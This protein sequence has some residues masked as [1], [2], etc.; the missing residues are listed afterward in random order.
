MT[1]FV[2]LM[3]MLVLLAPV[4]VADEPVCL[5]FC[6]PGYPGNT[7]EAQ[8]TMDHFASG[9]NSATGWKPGTLTAVYHESGSAGVERLSS[10]DAAVAIV[11]LPFYLK[12]R[13]ELALEPL[14]AAV[15]T[16]GGEGTWS[17][18]AAKGKLS[19]P[20]DLAG[21]TVTGLPAYLPALVRGP[22]LS[23]WGELP[24]NMT[25]QFTSRA[26]SALRKASR[27]E[28][29]AVLLDV[30]QIE[31]LSS[32]PFGESLEVVHTSG[33]L[34]GSVL[35]SVGGRLPEARQVELVN[36]LLAMGKAPEGTQLLESIRL[37]RFEKVNLEK[38]NRIVE[39]MD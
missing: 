37:E 22:V 7:A 38:I 26:L 5:V 13:D 3:S 21:W 18:V 29:V 28:T 4:A 39:A 1:R 19:G 16:D 15:A 32:L 8:P 20:G 27:G 9:L 14:L 33:P 10:S 2:R 34:P 25:I 23:G 17:L 11:S 35:C 12:H 30:P 36:A 24:E 31:A 6:A